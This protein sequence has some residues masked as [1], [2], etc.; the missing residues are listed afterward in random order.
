MTVGELA[1]FHAKIDKQRRLTRRRGVRG[2]CWAW[3]GATNSSGY[4]VLR[5]DG[6]GGV[7]EV[8]LAHRLSYEH[9][10]GPIP[11]GLEPDHLCE[12][13]DCVNPEHV[14]PVTHLENMR[15]SMSL[16]RRGSCARGHRATRKNLIRR[17][18]GFVQCRTCFNLTRRLR[19]H[20]KREAKLL[21]DRPASY[22]A[23]Q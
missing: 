20:E 16:E 12:Q 1:R 17:S 19:Y 21:S 8:R 14:E 5:L 2:P 11:E 13:S 9:F 4:A 23:S 3:T 22:T 10:I 15:R 6:H 7:D 18:D